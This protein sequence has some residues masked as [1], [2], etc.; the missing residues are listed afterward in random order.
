MRMLSTS[1]A[2]SLFWLGRTSKN[3]VTSLGIMSLS[4]DDIALINTNVAGNR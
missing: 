4:N 3:V 1:N 2:N